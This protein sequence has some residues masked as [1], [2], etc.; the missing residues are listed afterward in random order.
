MTQ[1]DG[2]CVE[3]WFIP[4]PDN[5]ADVLGSSGA[6]LQTPEQPHWVKSCNVEKKKKMKEN[7]RILLVLIFVVVF[8]CLAPY[9]I[10]PLRIFIEDPWALIFNAKP[11]MNQCYVYNSSNSKKVWFIACAHAHTY[12]H[13]H[14]LTHQTKTLAYLCTC[15]PQKHPGSNPDLHHCWWCSDCTTWTPQAS[16]A[17]PAESLHAASL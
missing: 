6:G 14:T 15:P 12:I 13:T 7:D 1:V 2:Q 17:I 9:F 10:T 8:C 3:R 11:T 5:H 4:V 16:S